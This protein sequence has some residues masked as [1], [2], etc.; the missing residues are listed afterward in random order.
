[1]T[2]NDKETDE[3]KQINLK[4]ENLVDMEEKQED[5][6][7]QEQNDEN[8]QTVVLTAPEA[9]SNDEFK[10]LFLKE[11]AEKDAEYYN[12]VLEAC[13]EDNPKLKNNQKELKDTAY[14]VLIGF[15]CDEVASDFLEEKI[16]D[17][18]KSL[19]DVCYFSDE[20]FVYMAT[21]AQQNGTS[22]S[23]ISYIYERLANVE[24]LQ[25]LLGLGKTIAEAR[26]YATNPE[27]DV[28]N[29]NTAKI[30]EQL[31]QF[32]P[33]LS[34]ENKAKINYIASKM[35]YRMRVEKADFGPA[36]DMELN[37]LRKALTYSSDYKLISYCQGRL[38]DPNDKIVLRAY[39]HALSSSKDRGEKAQ[40]NLA[41]ADIYTSRAT[42]IGFLTQNSDKKISGEKALHHLTDAYRYS[43]KDSCIHIL[44]RIAE[45]QRNLGRKEDWK[46]TKT[47]IALKFLKGE[48][49]C[50]ALSSI[51]DKTNDLSYYHKAIAESKKAKIPAIS[52]VRIQEIVYGKLLNRLPEGEERA[53]VAKKLEHVKKQSSAD[54]RKLFFIKK[55]KSK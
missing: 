9:L 18:Y 12:D 17:A 10:N 24:A 14:D 38:F 50:M 32:E 45:M 28:N 51:A 23:S 20:D 33:D 5:A 4:E 3:N 27:K 19:L 40:I 48:E 39:K 41:L 16:E 52:K 49:R 35:Y 1:M 42:K 46:N 53:D 55:G 44:K 21:L 26:D 25:P 47:V 7:V 6:I 30:L 36:K 22:V 37:C 13:I 34:A 29:Y 54:M 2:K 31:N 11:I 15:Y 8:K 43:P